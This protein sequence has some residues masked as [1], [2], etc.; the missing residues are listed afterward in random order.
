V[1]T[2]FR[3]GQTLLRY[4]Y[5]K[6]LVYTPEQNS[7][8]L[9]AIY[10]NEPLVDHTDPDKPKEDNQIMEYS[11]YRFIIFSDVPQKYWFLTLRKLCMAGASDY[12]EPGISAQGVFR[13]DQNPCNPDYS[14][15]S[16]FTTLWRTPTIRQFILVIFF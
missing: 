1:F 3:F 16:I 12:R 13:S 6:D 9:S 10:F 4:V 11:A 8:F 2:D 5:A 7:S 15:D 14:T